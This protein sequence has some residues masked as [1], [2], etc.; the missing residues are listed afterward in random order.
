MLHYEMIGDVI[1][2]RAREEEEKIR[3]YKLQV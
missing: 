1:K 2:F 3:D